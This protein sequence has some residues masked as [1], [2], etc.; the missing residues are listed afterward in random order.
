MMSSQRIISLWKRMDWLFVANVIALIIVGV[1]FIYS[2]SSRRDDAQLTA[3]TQR[4]ILWALVGFAAFLSAV[5]VDYRNV[6]RGAIVFYLAT[7]AMLVLVLLVG[8]KISGATRWLSLFG[9]L[10]QPAEFAKLATILMLAHY[11][12]E[13]SR[14]LAHPRTLLI[15]L[16][17]LAVPGVLIMEQ[18]DLGT[19]MTL[20]PVT[21][22]MLF[23]GGVPFRYLAVLCLL[24]LL[25]VIPGWF[26]LDDYQRERLLV[27]FD[28]GRD[29]LGAGWNS[30]QSSIAVG[31]GGLFG[32]GYLMGTQNV[33]GFLP[34]TVAPTD[35]I[36]SVIAEE[37]G[38]VGS[39]ALL[40]L[41]A[42]LLGSGL[43]ASLASRD[44]LGRLLSVGIVTLLFSHAFVNM[45]MTVG[46]MP[47]TGLPLPLVSYGGSFMSCTMAGLGLVQSVYVRRFRR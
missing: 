22:A 42:L 45:A 20:V 23:V 41:F 47:I 6:N 28:P 46:L 7:I 29:P 26:T 13:P 18:P 37:T 11:L 43:R 5:T 24:G 15:A 17:L 4:Q 12:S 31:S 14:D 3:M 30:I 10:I 33:L 25:A 39:V 44:K 38:F 36:F 8:Q 34:R 2:A 9:I 1:M 19:A 35:F 27:F 21:F 16:L 32:K 40:A